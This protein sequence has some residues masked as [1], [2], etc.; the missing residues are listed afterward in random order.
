MNEHILICLSNK[1]IYKIDIKSLEKSMIY[2]TD[3]NIIDI[4]LINRF[5]VINQDN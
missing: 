5:L 2:T 4:K 3:R 1:E